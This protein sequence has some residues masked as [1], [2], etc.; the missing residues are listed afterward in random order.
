MSKDLV[1]NSRLEEIFIALLE[2]G[3]LLELHKEVANKYF[4]VGDLY[5]G[6]VRKISKSLNAAFINI[7]GLKDA[8][9]HYQDLGINIKCFINLISSTKK[10]NHQF[11]SNLEL[12]KCENINKNGN[13]NDVLKIGQK[14]LVQ[15]TK[16]PISNK[17]PRLT[18]EISIAGRYLILIPFLK[19]ISISHRIKDTLE[20]E[21][22]INIIE[23]IK[24]KNFGIIIRT[25]SQ[26]KKFEILESDLI[27]LIKK[28]NFVINNI[29]KKLPPFKILSENKKVSCI[30]RDTFD[31]N[32]TSI[33]CDDKSLY[34]DISSYIYSIDP[35]KNNIV[36]Y[37]NSKI[38]IF[39]KYGIEKQIKTY[40]GKNI[41]FGKGS[42]LIIEHTEAF[43]VIDVNSG[44]AQNNINNN[45]V[46]EINILAANEIA[47][48]IRL[49]DM[50]GIIVIDFIDMNSSEDKKYLYDHFKKIMEKDRVKHK[51]LPP[52][53]FGLVQ[54]TR[55]RVK[56]EIKIITNEPNPNNLTNEI[57][58]PISHIYHIELILESIIKN[59]NHKKIYLHTH[60]FITAYLKAG[61][62]SIRLKWVIRYKKW[63][64]IIPRHSFRY[65]EYLITDEKNQILYSY[66][67]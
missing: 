27:Y 10:L 59:K 55:Q 52:S 48:Q 37:Y 49:R 58:S 56:P 26:N 32:F 62:F 45:S 35:K 66:K 67:N 61:F 34:N 12:Y 46:L 6:K 44:I 43:H 16:E 42:Y 20:R 13:I 8:F 30:L 65:L 19:K 11:N 51:I 36:K 33:I 3:K 60:P 7:G 5:I 24:P 14:I 53:K 57:S 63:I 4:C 17:G 25:V 31:S 22:L 1:I 23:K 15:I 50:G 9:L 28:W 47:R 38:P 40:L 39:E 18:S 54:M 41:P 21:R 29:F 2:N 64:F